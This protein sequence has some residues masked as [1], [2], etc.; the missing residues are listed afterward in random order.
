MKAHYDIDSG[1]IQIWLP[2]GTVISVLR[3]AV[4]DELNLGLAQ[5]SEFNK[6]LYDYPLELVEMLL[7]GKLSG[8]LK[9]QAHTQAEQEDLISTQLQAQGYSPTQADSLTREY[10][11]Y[12]V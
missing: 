2:D 4:E 11:R 6:L 3:E 1:M 10:L 8:Y 12:D 9:T 7:A 5:E